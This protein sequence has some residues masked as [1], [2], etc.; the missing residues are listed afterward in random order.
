[1]ILVC[2]QQSFC[3]GPEDIL[4]EEDL[5]PAEL[6]LASEKGSLGQGKALLITKWIVVAGDGITEVMER[7]AGHLHGA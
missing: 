2:Y 7:A 4:I 6:P 3:L 1:M 5:P